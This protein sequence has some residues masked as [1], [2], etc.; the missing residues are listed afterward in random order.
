VVGRESAG[1]TGREEELKELYAEGPAIH[2][3]AVVTVLHRCGSRLT[4]EPLLCVGNDL[5]RTDLDLALR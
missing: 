5:A 1:T 4:G 2:G 3:G